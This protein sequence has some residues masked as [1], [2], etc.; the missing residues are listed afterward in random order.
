MECK[1]EP[2]II[3]DSK[4]VSESIGTIPVAKAVSP[5]DPYVMPAAAPVKKE[6]KAKDPNLFEGEQYSLRLSE[7]GVVVKSY[8]SGESFL[9]SYMEIESFNLSNKND[10]GVFTISSDV[11]GDF[12]VEFLN[13]HFRQLEACEFFNKVRS[14]ID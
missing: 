6:T 2:K 4:Q 5:A 10:R 13:Y 9:F 1:P 8:I 11:N 12:E 3:S 7:K 14:I